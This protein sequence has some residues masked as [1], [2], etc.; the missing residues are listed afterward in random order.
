MLYKFVAQ[1]QQAIPY[2]LGVWYS[3]QYYLGL[4]KNTFAQRRNRLT[5][6]FSKLIPVVKRLIYVYDLLG[7]YV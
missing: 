7:N 1:E 2:S 6:R 5:T 3:I 4:C